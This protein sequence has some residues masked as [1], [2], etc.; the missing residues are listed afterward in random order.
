MYSFLEIHAN[1]VLVHDCEG[2]H[3][4]DIDE[5][6]EDELVADLFDR[7]NEHST[8]LALRHE[9]AESD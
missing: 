4:T 6:D 3:D 5:E 8:P 9:E 2:S 1:A 7:D